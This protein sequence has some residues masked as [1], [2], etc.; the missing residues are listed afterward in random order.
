MLVTDAAKRR[1]DSLDPVRET[2]TGD[3]FGNRLSHRGGAAILLE[4]HQMI[5]RSYKIEGGRC[6]R[7]C[8]VH[9]PS[10]TKM[11]QHFGTI[12]RQHTMSNAPPKFTMLALDGA[13]A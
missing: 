12:A 13:I 9:G 7:P 3:T 4:L 2:H 10:R 11:F 5:D 8:K 1:G 6:L